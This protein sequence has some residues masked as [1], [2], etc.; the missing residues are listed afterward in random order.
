MPETHAKL[1]PSAAH[2]WLHCTA[3]PSLEAGIPDPGSPYAAEGTLAHSIAELKLRKALI[4]PMGPKKFAGKLKKLQEDPAYDPEM[5]T[6]ADAYVDYI[7][8]LV[9][10]FES[11]PYVAAETRLDL[12]S[13]APGCFGTAD[14]LVIGNGELHVV[15]FKY[16][17]GLQV[18][19]VENP[20]LRLYGIGAVLANSL[21]YDIKT[22]H[23]HIF[24]PRLDHVS[25]E[26][27]P[28]EQLLDWGVFQVAPKAK[29]AYDGPGEHHAGDWCQ[30]CRAKGQCRAQA[31][32]LL[33]TIRPY[34]DNDPLL[35]SNHDYAELLP[36]LTPLK[37]WIAQ[38]EDAALH[39]LL[40][41]EDIAGY[42]LVEGRSVRTFSDQDAAFDAI[43]AAGY[44]RDLLYERKPLT[45]SG[46]EKLIGKTK[47]AEIAGPYIQKPAGAPTVV[48]ISDKRPPYT[49]KP[50]PEEAFERMN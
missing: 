23:L 20:Q 37:S 41:G 26:T 15:D 30:F 1:S 17:K 8:S 29:E 12:T 13:V 45:L 16:G 14:C 31:K 21:F 50:T 40:T 19:A 27:V 22:V 2:R 44:D 36:Q 35:L 38:I 4:E 10:R 6:H 33:D 7:K 32:Q 5:L 28:R 9:H 43:V 46:T 39:R 42:K 47:F 25:T 34:R 48:P 24:Q 3:A 18:E 49:V 11:K